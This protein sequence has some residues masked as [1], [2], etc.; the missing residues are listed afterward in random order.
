MVPQAERDLGD[1]QATDLN[2]RPRRSY[3]HLFQDELWRLYG[4][5]LEPRMA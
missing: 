5:N 3:S 1:L 4:L 2:L